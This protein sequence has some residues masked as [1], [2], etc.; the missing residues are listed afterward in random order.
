MISIPFTGEICYET[1]G[2]YSGYAKILSGR[3]AII[4]VHKLCKN[5]KEMNLLN[6]I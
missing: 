2:Q 1:D 6:L 3:T 5:E 4:V